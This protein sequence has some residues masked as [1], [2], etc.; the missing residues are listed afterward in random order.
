MA[1]PY[2]VHPKPYLLMTNLLQRFTPGLARPLLLALTVLLASC[3]SSNDGDDPSPDAFAAPTPYALVLPP[4]FP[5]PLAQPANN[6]LTVEGVE[7]GRQLFY[8]KAL[9]VDNSKSCG[10]CHQQSKAFTDGLARAEGVGGTRHARS[11]MP[12]Q[13]LLWEPRLTWDG[14]HTSLEQQAR[15]PIENPLELHQPLSAG[16]A[17]L[18]Q[19]TKYPALFGRAFGQG[20]ITEENVL[21]A[22]AQFERTLISADSRFDR[23]RRGQQSVLSADEVRGMELFSIHPNGRIRGG[24][25]SDCHSG[26]LQTD[27]NFRNNGLD[28]TFGADLGLGALTGK[29]TDNGKFRVPSLRNIALTAPYMHDGRLATLEDV[30]D[31]Y[32]EHVQFNSPNLDPLLL[33]TTNDPLQENPNLGLTAQEKKQIIAFL[34]TL[35]DSAFITDPRFAEPK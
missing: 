28:A 14:A 30:L 18:R 3:A 17:R 5:T 11:A 19:T 27:R 1:G 9:S 26:V 8:E 16:V 21:K 34:R 24:N 12:L 23:Y 13:N 33:N 31:H 2:L 25:C 35:T 10:S 32:N 7:L 22:L 6:P 20:A 15:T 29:P 4:L